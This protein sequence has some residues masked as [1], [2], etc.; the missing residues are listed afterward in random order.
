MR[1]NELVIVPQSQKYEKMIFVQMI[2]MTGNEAH[3]S[4]DWWNNTQIWLYI[5]TERDKEKV[6]ERK[7]DESHQDADRWW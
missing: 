3:T 7:Q 6:G 1:E 2:T 5:A 4:I